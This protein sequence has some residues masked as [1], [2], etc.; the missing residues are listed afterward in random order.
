MKSKV[1][2]APWREPA[3]GAGGRGDPG[4]KHPSEMKPGFQS[5]LPGALETQELQRQPWRGAQGP[6]CV[7]SKGRAVCTLRGPPGVRERIT[8]K[9]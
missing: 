2:P 4:R 9:D 6:L 7:F 8:Q 3:G 1:R 5:S